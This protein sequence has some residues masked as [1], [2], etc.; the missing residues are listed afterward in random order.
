MNDPTN[1][2]QIPEELRD[3]QLFTLQELEPLLDVTNRTLLSY[4]KS[5]RLQ[6][7][8][9]GGKWR[10][11]R[12]ALDRFLSGKGTAGAGDTRNELGAV[13]SRPLCLPRQAGNQDNPEQAPPLS[14]PPPF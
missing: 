6:A 1:K 9:I 13:D 11:T 2:K 10:V 8:K 7:V 3:I 12:E 4:V 5:G 14:E